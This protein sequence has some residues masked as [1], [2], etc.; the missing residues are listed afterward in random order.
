MTRFRLVVLGNPIP[1]PRAR[2]MRHG[3]HYTPDDAREMKERIANAARMFGVPFFV[4]PLL[5]DLDVY[6][7]PAGITY[8]KRGSGDRDNYEKLVTDALEGVCFA[9]DACIVDGRT[10]KLPAE[11]G[12]P[13]I[14]AVLEGTTGKRPE[15]KLKRFRRSK[16]IALPSVYQR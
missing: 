14:E 6:L 10:R 12:R 8:W 13:R 4:G 2:A 15:P 5:M 7:D 11:D 3:H 16:L 9:N 1:M